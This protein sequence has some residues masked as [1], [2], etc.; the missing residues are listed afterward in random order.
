MRS[1]V[2]ITSASRKVSLVK[3]FNRWFDTVAIDMD[4][5]SPALHFATHREI[6]PS[7]LGDDYLEF[8]K[9]IVDKYKIDLIV[10]TR[11]A[12]LLFFCEIAPKLPCRVMAA[13]PDTIIKCMDK[14]RFYHFCLEND[15]LVAPMVTSP[16]AFVRERFGSG[17]AG[18]MMARDRL[19]LEFA[20]RACE[21]PI[22]QQIINAPEYTVDL[23]SDFEGNVISVVPRRRIKIVG[24][25]SYVG[26]TE[27]NKEII[28]EST[29]LAK[30]LGLIGHNTI[31]CFFIDG[32]YKDSQ[33]VFIEVNPRFGGGCALGFAAGV[34]TPRL[35]ADLIEGRDIER[36]N[37]FKSGVI[38]L[39]YT[40]DLFL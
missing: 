39:R 31:Q 13:V 10:P 19:E 4:T 18:A 29:R 16:P 12:E 32:N 23:F 11:D 6:S 2:L 1:K 14:V 24:G 35:L 17:S 36:V 7:G 34:S 26:R 27:Y 20:L 9:G 33:V 5:N 28:D 21:S 25:E 30:A 22:I 15:F 40:E 8:I 3:E 37:Y 38:M